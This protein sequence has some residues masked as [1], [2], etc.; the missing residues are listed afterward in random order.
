M[1][2]LMKVLSAALLGVYYLLFVAAAVLT[3]A[4]EVMGW[5]GEKAQEASNALQKGW[6]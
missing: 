3:V 2:P 4:A 1:K 5:V 6:P